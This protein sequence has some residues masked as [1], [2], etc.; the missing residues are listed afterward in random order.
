MPFYQLVLAT[1][2]SNYHLSNSSSPFQLKTRL[3]KENDSVMASFKM[4]QKLL[5]EELTDEQKALLAQDG[6]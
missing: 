5:P 2:F 4:G 3:A 6:N 1:R